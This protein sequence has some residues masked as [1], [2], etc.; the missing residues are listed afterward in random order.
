[1]YEALQAGASGFLLKD[2]PPKELVRAVRL[3]AAG[4][5]LLSPA[6]TQ[7]LIN[8]YVR[9]RP[10]TNELPEGLAELTPR[11]LEVFR[12]L[13]NGKSNAEIG[14]E[15]FLTEGT[16]K[17]HMTRILQKLEL[18]DRVQAVVY[19]YESGFSR[20]GIS[21]DRTDLGSP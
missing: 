19:S 11:E 2:S 17:T 18:R 8:T 16:V 4:E 9:Q 10:D 1:M 12:L 14:S 21:S 5:A 13:A 7:M 15:L 3:V 6:I 20:P